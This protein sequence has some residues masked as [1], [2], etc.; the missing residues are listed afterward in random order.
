MSDD[1]LEKKKAKELAGQVR[2]AIEDTCGESNVEVNVKNQRL[3]SVDSINDESTDY[4]VTNISF[5]CT[6]E[7]ANK[8]QSE[9]ADEGDKA[10]NKATATAEE[11]VTTEPEQAVTNHAEPE[12]Q[13]TDNG[14]GNVPA[15]H[16]SSNGTGTAEE[17]AK[18]EEKV[19]AARA[20]EVGLAAA[21][22][23]EDTPPVTS[24]EGEPVTAKKKPS[25]LVLPIANLLEQEAQLGFQPGPK[26]ATLPTSPGFSRN[27]HLANLE[28]AER[29]QALKRYGPRKFGFLGGKPIPESMASVLTC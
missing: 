12:Q 23:V 5:P 13:G 16:T 27:S 8:K 28:P 4:V 3:V 20:E 7:S 10:D 15:D 14:N 2:Q 6:T 29:R 22:G 25:A 18:E 11:P 9:P 21:V 19:R 26:T 1:L 17:A 24:T